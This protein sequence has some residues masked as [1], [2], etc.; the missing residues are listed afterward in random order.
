MVAQAATLSSEQLLVVGGFDGSNH[1][2]STEVLD[3]PKPALKE[4][5]L[6]GGGFVTFCRIP[7]GEAHVFHVGATPEHLAEWLCRGP[8]RAEANL[9]S[10]EGDAVELRLQ[11]H[12][13]CTVV[14]ARLQP[15]ADG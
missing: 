11:L 8:S 2:D 14:H 5:S 10:G 4:C 7:K 9:G 12:C 1:L 13:I 6:H 3:A 15:L